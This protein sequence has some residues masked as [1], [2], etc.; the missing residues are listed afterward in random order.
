MLINKRYDFNKMRSFFNL[1]KLEA[2][3]ERDFILT[4][5]HNPIGWGKF[6]HLFI[7][8]SLP[9]YHSLPRV[10]YLFPS[11]FSFLSFPYFLSSTI[12]FSLLP[13]SFLFLSSPLFPRT[14]TAAPPLFQHPIPSPFFLLFH[15]LPLFFSVT[16]TPMREAEMQ[17]CRERENGS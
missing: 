6:R 4:T 14:H 11:S 3:N 13:S 1:S 17:K 12:T 10:P 7:S 2:L 15:F 16:H 5:C 9:T 8:S